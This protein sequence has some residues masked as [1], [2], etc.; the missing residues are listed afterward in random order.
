MGLKHGHWLTATEQK[1]S[2]RAQEKFCFSGDFAVKMTVFILRWTPEAHI[3]ILLIMV[4]KDV[5]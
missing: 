2:V 4:S 1:L 3:L 5:S